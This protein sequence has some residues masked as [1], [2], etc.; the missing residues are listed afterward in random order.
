VV[1]VRKF[2]CSSI[3][4]MPSAKSSSGMRITAAFDGDE[5]SRKIKEEE[6]SDDGEDE[7]LDQGNNW[8]EKYLILYIFN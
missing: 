4:S 1:E 7:N 5:Q 6:E 3:P 2:K 8:E